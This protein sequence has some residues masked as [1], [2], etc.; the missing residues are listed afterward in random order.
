MDRL[1]ILKNR[2]GSITRSFFSMALLEIAQ[3]LQET[4]ISVSIRESILMFPLLEGGHLL[5]ISVSAG[6]IAISDLR[7]MGLIFKK[8][9]ASDVFHQLIPWISAGFL[10]MIVTGT[11]LLWSEPVKC[12]NS[13]WF[14]LKVLFLFLAGLNVLIF[15]SSKIYRNMHEWE[16]SSDPPRAAKLAGWISLIS[17]AIVII[18]LRM[19]GFGLKKQ[20]V[21]VLAKNLEPYMTWGL[22]TMLATGYMLFTSE[23]MKCF[24]NDGF[25][26]KMAFLFPAIIFQFT[27]FRWITHKD[28]DKRPMLLGWLVAVLSLVLWSVV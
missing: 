19:L 26:F 9:S 2:T 6:T 24:V 16:W 17:W 22:V 8:E 10:M 18:D 12:Y 3:W 1:C 7:M 13:I 25:K 14:R 28:E 11:L 15:H 27:L 5:G 20:P 21:T 23:A 4:P